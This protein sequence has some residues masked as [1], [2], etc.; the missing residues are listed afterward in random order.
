MKWKIYPMTFGWIECPKNMLTTGLDENIIIKIPYLGYYLT[1]GSHKVLVDNGINEKYIVD[2]KA[3]AGRPAEGGEKFVVSEFERIGVK[4][5]D[6]DTVIYT[7]LHNDHVGNCHLF[8]YATH[9]FQNIEWKE[10]LDP[11]PSMRIRGDYDQSIV[12]EL[13]KLK[14]DIVVGDLEYFEGLSFMLTPGHTRGSQCIIVDTDKGKYLLSG[15]TVHIRHIAYGYLE[16]MKLMDGSII[17]VTTAPKEWQEISPS[18]LVYDH[19]SWFE[20]IY[21]IKSMFKDPKM[22]LTGHG[23][24]IGTKIYG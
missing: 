9:V 10:L 6:I 12:Q 13:K 15:D 1:D 7:H 2:G 3:W 17:D 4:L 22:V 8:P 18:S 21:R 11:L 19:Y 24:Y 16:K 20:S 5:S 23:P 14:C